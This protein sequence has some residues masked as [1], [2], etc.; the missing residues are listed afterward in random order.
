MVRGAWKSWFLLTP[1]H[2]PGRRP[3]A[4]VGVKAEG[5]GGGVCSTDWHL[6]S[7]RMLHQRDHNRDH[8]RPPGH[9]IATIPRR[10]LEP[11]VTH[12]THFK[13]RMK[14]HSPGAI[15]TLYRLPC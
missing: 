4:G 6:L 11:R 1:E 10:S 2:L 13:K 12:K 8:N 7:T 14:Q 5:A 15:L 9:M 3:S